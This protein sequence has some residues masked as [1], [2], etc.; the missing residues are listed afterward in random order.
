MYPQ[1]AHQ[2]QVNIIVPHLLSLR[3]IVI[4]EWPFGR[5]PIVV[6]YPPIHL[7]SDRRHSHVFDE[8]NR[9]KSCIEMNS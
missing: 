2:Y 4:R 8:W 6:R 3:P 9:E 7:L 1:L 5:R